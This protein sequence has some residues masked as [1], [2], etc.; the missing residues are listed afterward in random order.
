MESFACEI[1]TVMLN[2]SSFEALLALKELEQQE[3]R[4]TNTLAKMTAI[5]TKKFFA[6]IQNKFK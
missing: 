6:F 5:I 4:T 2:A 1:G 3:K